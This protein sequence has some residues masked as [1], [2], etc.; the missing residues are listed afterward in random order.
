MKILKNIIW[1]L[2]ERAF[3]VLGTIISGIISRQLGVVEYGEF[4]YI[5]ASVLIFSAI[6][7]VCGSE[8]LVPK[9]VI[10][11]KDKINSLI[12]SGFLLRFLGSL[13]A[14]L[15]LVIYG[16]IFIDNGKIVYLLNL[17]G[18]TVLAR[19]P[20]AV[21]Q[22]YFQAKTFSAP[23]AA[24]SII[25]LFIKILVLICA[26]YL[27]LISLKFLSVVW[28]FEA[29]ILSLIYIKLYIREMREVGIPNKWEFSKFKELFEEGVIY[30]FPLILMNIF[31]RVDRLI[32]KNNASATEAGIYMAAM[33]LYDAVVS[34]A[35]IVSI[36]LAPVF[37]Y[38]N[39]SEEKIHNNTIKMVVI[40]MMLGLFFAISGY[41]IS[42][43]IVPL[44]FGI[45]FINAIPI[46][47]SGLCIS[48]LVFLD[49]ALNVNLIKR[50]G[51]KHALIK[52]ILIVSV[53]VP[54]QYFSVQTWGA[55]AAQYGIAVG[56]GVALVYG[57]YQL[58]IESK[59]KENES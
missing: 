24:T 26:Y 32:V 41:Y 19:E 33:Q 55:H 45:N 29:I 1:L 14:Y 22:A 7:L 34:V 38:K 47:Q 50:F 6:G 54:I 58:T 11:K 39:S 56:Y 44:I 8:V 17:I 43:I 12:A 57:L 42:P 5:L 52:W 2:S 31:W 18:L 30:W 3:Q 4:Q 15:I 9:L 25:I 46:V 23:V 35:L 48:V 40:M 13:I 16:Q 53:G 28:I 49:A 37:I 51:A 21:V 20:F 36:S 59:G 27:K 10:S